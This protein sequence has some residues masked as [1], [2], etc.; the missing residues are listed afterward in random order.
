MVELHDTD[1]RGHNSVWVY[2]L[3]GGFKGNIFATLTPFATSD[4]AS[5]S[6]IPVIGIVSSALTAAS[7]IP[8]AKMLDLWGRAE[9]VLLMAGFATLGTIMLAASKNLPTYCAATV[10]SAKSTKGFFRVRLIAS[11]S[12]NQLVR[13]ERSMLWKS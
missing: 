3:V 12:S 6:L 4:F 13:M 5:H 8:I 1:D 7:Y 11:R 10:Y 2:Y 9:G